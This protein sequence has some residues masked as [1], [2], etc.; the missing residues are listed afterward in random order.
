[1][2]EP[3]SSEI[4][5]GQR[6]FSELSAKAKPFPG[7][8]IA[9]VDCLAVCDTPVVIAFTAQDKWSYVIGAANPETDACDILSV[10][11]AIAASPHGIPAMADRP[12]FFRKGVISRAPPT[13]SGKTP[14]N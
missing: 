10:A 2:T 4:T 6:L 8:T 13:P 12:Q 9:E 7:I 1:M 11:Q 5:D 14:E 3:G